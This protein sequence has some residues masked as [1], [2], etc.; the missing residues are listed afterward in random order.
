VAAPSAL[1]HPVLSSR[2]FFPRPSALRDPFFVTTAGGS[3]R[4]GCHL[5]RC[6]VRDAPLV[7]HFH[8]NGEVVGDHIP[9]TAA[10]FR[11]LGV[12]VLL[13]EY[14]GYGAST[15]APSLGT[16]L[17]DAEAVFAATGV[18]ERRVVLFGRSLGSLCAIELAARHPR[19]AGLVIE[20]GIADVLERVLLRVA[21]DEIGVTRAALEDA[22]AARFDHRA[23]LARFGGP[24]LAMHAARDALVAA[25]H[26]ERNVAWGA[27]PTHDK[28]L[29]LLPH[30]DHNTI[31]PLNR[32]AYLA[33]LG[34]FLR[35]VG[36]HRSRG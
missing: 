24:M 9:E 12:D 2:Y 13:A 33:A 18:E 10:A 14:R 30:G 20:S 21:P 26:A 3:A 1:D 28:Q 16:M 27:A 29:V 17:D 25:S 8:G 35:R 6:G 4:L 19:V 23:K 34:D 7:L 32:A 11:A 36:G 5:A 22:V 15:G 31:F